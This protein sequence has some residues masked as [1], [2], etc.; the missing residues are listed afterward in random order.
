MRYRDGISS[1]GSKTADDDAG[2]QLSYLLT[3]AA[4]RPRPRAMLPDGR[5]VFDIL[6]ASTALV[7]TLPVLLT[8]CA[9]VG[10]TMHRKVFFL[11]RR[12][13]KDG[14]LFVLVKLRSLKDVRSGEEDGDRERRLTPV[15]RFIR[16]FGIDELPQF[17]NVLKGDMSIFG[18]RPFDIEPDV[19]G[20]K[21]R[22]LIKPGLIGLASIRE[23]ARGIE[24]PLAKVAI[25]DAEYIGRRTWKLDAWLFVIALACIVDGRIDPQEQT[26]DS[27]RSDFFNRLAG[28]S[29]R[30]I[31]GNDSV[32]AP[33]AGGELEM[34]A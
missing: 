18:P 8:A 6:V 32:P 14:R 4:R 34:S 7:A 22:Y 21:T 3:R 10:L 5:R 24:S 9:A 28:A 12:H 17:I 25:D 19:D 1:L 31:L 23:K 33:A 16:R 27:G 30:N 13:G 29:I 2:A 11:Q 15:G 26:I 20:W